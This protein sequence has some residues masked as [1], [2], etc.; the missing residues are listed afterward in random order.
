MGLFGR[1]KEQAKPDFSSV[2]SG[3]SSTAPA[4]APGPPP[5]SS[6]TYVVAK[7]DSLSKISLQQYGTASLW[8][9]IYEANRESITDPDLI[10][11]GQQLLIPAAEKA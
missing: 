10:Y 9:R 2:R 5:A 4:A 3:S 6:D 8:R 1:K 11:P 7:G